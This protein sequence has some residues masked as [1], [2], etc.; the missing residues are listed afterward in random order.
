MFKLDRMS[1]RREIDSCRS[2][3]GISESELMKLPTYVRKFYIYE[4]NNRIEKINNEKNNNT[5]Q[6][7]NR[8]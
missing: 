7:K 5:K 8:R 1:F 4:H 6:K 3:I 2:Y